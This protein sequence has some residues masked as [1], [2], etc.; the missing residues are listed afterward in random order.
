MIAS[1]IIA[2]QHF[3]PYVHLFERINMIFMGGF[4]IFVDG[5]LKP[6]VEGVKINAFIWQPVGS[7]VVFSRCSSSGD[8]NSELLLPLSNYFQYIFPAIVFYLL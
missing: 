3:P 2:Y 5:N 7:H 4:C 6:H 8:D 1:D